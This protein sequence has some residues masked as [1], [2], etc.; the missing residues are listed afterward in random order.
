MFFDAESEQHFQELVSAL[1]EGSVTGFI[2][3]G[4]SMPH[5]PGWESLYATLQ[6]EAGIEQ[7]PVFLPDCAPHEFEELRGLIGDDRFLGVLRQTYGGP[8]ASCPDSYHIL[9]QIAGFDH[10]ITTNIDE[11]LATAAASHDRDPAI[12][13]YPELEPLRA[14][15]VY[16]HGRA[17]TAKEPRELVL[18]ESEYASAYEPTNGRVT[19]RLKAHLQVGDM[20]FIGCSMKDYDAMAILRSL[21]RTPNAH[22][23]RLGPQP[24][25]M[26]PADPKM[27]AHQ[28][29][30]AEAVAIESRRLKASGIRPIWYLWDEGH[31]HLRALLEQLRYE[32]KPRVTEPLF[33]DR[34]DEIDTLT[35]L[36][37][38]TEQEQGRV[39]ELIR[40]VPELA[41]HFFRNA[42]SVA[43]YEVLRDEGLLTLVVEPYPDSG[44]TVRIATWAAAP[45]V[46]RIAP[47]RPDVVAELMT[48]LR[49]TENWHVRN[50][51]AD[52]AASVPDDQVREVLPIL[53]EWRESGYGSMNL[54]R[55]YL[56]GL[57][58]AVGERGQHDLAL[59]L[60]S[61]LLVPTINEKGEI[62]VAIE[63]HDLERVSPVLASLTR[64]RPRDTYAVLKTQL[65][66][67]L[68]LRN[69]SSFWRPAIEEHE[70]NQV[71]F[72]KALHFILNWTR[73][74]LLSRISSEPEV[75]RLE[76]DELLSSEEPLLRRLALHALVESPENIAKVQTPVFTD[77]FFWNPRHFHELMLLLNR[78]FGDLSE[79]Q[80]DLVHRFIKEGPPATEDESSD[81]YQRRV[82]D[83]RWHL[84]AALPTEHQTDEE[85]KW[86]QEFRETRGD[87]E[88]P[89]FHTYFRFGFG[90]M[91]PEEDDRDLRQARQRGMRALLDELRE[92]GGIWYGLRELVQDDPDGMLELADILEAQDLDHLW[93][94]F[95]AYSDVMK[96]G[97]AFRWAPLIGFAERLAEQSGR[98]QT[99][100]STVSRLLR[101]GLSN[102]TAGVPDDF[103]DRSFGVLFRILHNTYISL[104]TGLSDDQRGGY[105]QLNS[106][107][108]EAADA[109]MLCIYRKTRKEQGETR[110]IP[111]IAQ[112]WLSKGLR[113]GWGGVELRHAV[114][115]FLRLLDWCE[116]GWARTNL[117]H[118]L[119]AGDQPAALNARRSLLNGYLSDSRLVPSLMKSLVPLYREAVPDTG[120]DRPVM[121][122]ERMA[123]RPLA[124]HIVVGWIWGIDGFGLDGLLGE[125]LAGASDDVRG[126]IVWFL[127]GE[128]EKADAEW[129]GELWRKMDE[130]WEY[131][132]EALSGL[133]VTERSEEL[134]RFCSWAKALDV[135]LE[136]LESRLNLSV[137]H[138][139][140]GFGIEELLQR[141]A[142][143][144]EHEAAPTARLLDR[145]VQRWGSDPNVFWI[146]RELEAAVDA[147]CRAA[148][149]MEI[150]PIRSIVD[151]LLKTGR[152]DYREK[153]KNLGEKG[154]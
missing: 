15:Y 89:F 97:I 52:L 103:L 152:A 87:P 36:E 29:S 117:Q 82:D 148:G 49:T 73:E 95:E 32:A 57:V 141:F 106:V 38:P 65:L 83:W 45:Y 25:A 3:A 8:V 66:Q 99:G 142:K 111:S 11:Y 27:C 37:T 139:S 96:V 28:Q 127:G 110:Q 146:G 21:N 46:Q 48:L 118:I 79:N 33:L 39:V 26:L 31:T 62:E 20:V 92:S 50:V 125:L 109:L 67:G 100:L 5:K 107:S 76:L 19:I 85:Q 132:V 42:T 126:H 16:L 128:Y 84:L 68:H 64:E 41:R 122:D 105:H 153:L 86:H 74:A 151:T 56:A 47:E 114:G 88:E 61:Q 58:K 115:Q 120:R 116:P 81:E 133:P 14:R 18:C 77:T 1:K 43:W 70:Q 143:R 131:R 54:V 23:Q 7:P 13:I 138:L 108:G 60:L 98:G 59:E 17:E 119:P 130:F 72:G 147:I 40:G 113:D 34:A 80:K 55:H 91:L 2:G 124:L 129:R 93:P 149:P 71:D 53:L 150:E 140:M 137:D 44:G 9:C 63:D 123:V 78:R 145:I 112:E 24:F 101:D 22:G 35:A 4:L 10:L 121:L 102:E 154:G 104:E 6:D 90:A 75:G 69:G 136:K 12:A 51:L 135:P 30:L 94:Y 144:G 134:T